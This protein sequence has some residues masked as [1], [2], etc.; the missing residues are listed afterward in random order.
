MMTMTGNVY[1]EV[2]LSAQTGPTL[3]SGLVRK[4]FLENSNVVFSLLFDN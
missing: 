2:E 3:R 1:L 4:I